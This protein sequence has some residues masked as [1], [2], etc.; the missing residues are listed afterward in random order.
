MWNMW[1][2]LND[3]DGTFKINLA[4]GLCTLNQVDP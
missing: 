2:P 3:E 1:K 4:V